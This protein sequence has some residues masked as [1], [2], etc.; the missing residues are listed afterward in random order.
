MT[1]N[2]SSVKQVESNEKNLHK[3]I[4]FRNIEMGFLVLEQ[5][6][7]DQLCTYCVAFIYKTFLETYCFEMAPRSDTYAHS[8]QR[9]I[10]TIKDLSKLHF[11]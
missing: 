3:F 7:I 8:L 2:L 4:T 6:Q 10:R 1:L 5:I 11:H 9:D